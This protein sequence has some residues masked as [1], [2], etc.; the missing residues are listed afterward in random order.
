MVK[1]FQQ[2]LIHILV[3]EVHLI[4]A[5]FKHRIDDVLNHCFRSVHVSVE[6]AERHFGLYLPKLCGM[7]SGVAVFGAEGRAE[8]INIAECKCKG[9]AMQLAADGQVTGLP[10]EVLGEVDLSVLRL[11]RVIHIEGCDAEHLAC[12]LTVAACKQR[13]VYINKPALIEEAVYRLGNYA[14][15][16]ENS[17]EGVCTGSEMLNGAEV[18]KAVTLLLKRI[19][20]R[21]FALDHDFLCMNLKRLL[22]VGSK[23]QLTPYS[24]SRAG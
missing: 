3:E 8:G 2:S 20:R 15:H 24:D 23:Y 17:L 14:A 10:K 9:F 11:G 16:T 7:A 19:I 1:P 4:G 13:S 12:T 5:A 6:I 21:A 22:C 18:F